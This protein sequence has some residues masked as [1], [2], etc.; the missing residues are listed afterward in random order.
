MTFAWPLLL[1]SLLVVPL[2]GCLYVRLLQL[3]DREAAA[4]GFQLTERASGRP[5]RR[6]YVAAGLF[7]AAITLL[8]AA[9]ARPSVTLAVPHTEGTVILAFDTSTSMTADDLEPTR[10]AAA[11]ATASEFVR[12]QPATVKVGVVAF[13]D[14]ALVV[15]P[16]STDQASILAAIDRLQPQGGTSLSEALFAALGSLAGRPIVLPPD[17]TEEQLLGL[18]LGYFGDA[19]IVLLSD[20]E[21]TSR[22]DPQLIAEVVAGAGVRV[23]PIGIGRAEGTTIEVEGYRLSTALNEELLQS[24]ATATS[25]EYF[26]A[27][28]SEQLAEVY[29]SID[30]KLVVEGEPTEVTGIV[31]G[32]A[33]LLLLLR[34]GLMM[35][36]FGSVT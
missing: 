30:L 13:G 16:P 11:K 9:L 28:D 10:L 12:A 15:Q 36:W 32:A 5:R 25:G 18:D 23:Y 31:A 34:S 27:E 19:A 8:L 14:S 1:A 6:R 2:L 33:L 26:R 3:R 20:G 22:L 35:H 21:H 17:I 7:L 24:I 4:I 29:D